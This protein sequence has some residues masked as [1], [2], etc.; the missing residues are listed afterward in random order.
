MQI[1]L[2]DVLKDDGKILRV[3]ADFGPDTFEM[4]LGKYPITRKTP[5][6]HEQRKAESVNTGQDGSYDSDSLRTLPGGSSGRV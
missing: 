4:K 3:D 2:N 5:G 6:S 1:A